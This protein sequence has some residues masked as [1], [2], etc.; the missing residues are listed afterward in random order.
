ERP[1]VA[2]TDVPLRQAWAR[3]IDPFAAIGAIPVAVMSL[4][5][6]SLLG[7][8]LAESFIP[9][10]GRGGA[11]TLNNFISVFS[12]PQTYQVMVNSLKFAVVSLVVAFGFGLPIAWLVESTDLK[13]KN[14]VMVLVLVTLLIPGFASAA[15]WLFLLHPRIG[16]ANVAIMHAFGLNA[17]PFNILTLA[18]MGWVEGLS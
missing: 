5:I 13:G 12:D 10:T 14:I 11:L 6:F 3:R 17:P 16:L 1:S 8:V 18:G 4:A 15:G 9:R 2:M 7:I